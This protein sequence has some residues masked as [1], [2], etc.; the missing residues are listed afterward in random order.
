MI[1]LE[2]RKGY[3]LYKDSN[4]KQYKL[5][6]Y[7]KYY[8]NTVENVLFIMHGIISRRGHTLEVHMME[9]CSI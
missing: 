8:E 7:A 3:Y 9:A 4:L 2:I 5:Q 1:L 6:S